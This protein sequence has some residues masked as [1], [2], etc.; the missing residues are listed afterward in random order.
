MRTPPKHEEPDDADLQAPP[1]LVS[2]LKRLPQERLFVPPAVDETVF[3]AA[4]E[5][6]AGDKLGKPHLRRGSFRE[7]LSLSVSWVGTA[8]RAVRGRPV[9]GRA[10]SAPYLARKIW[11]ATS[12]A[13]LVLVLVAY[14]FFS[15]GRGRTFGVRNPFAS[16]PIIETVRT[17]APPNAS[18][19]RRMDILDAFTL[20]RQLKSGPVREPRW[21]INR[22][23]VVDERDVRAIAV[24]VVRLDKGGRS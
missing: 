22:D 2:A 20:A 7:W 18:P 16:R 14:Q 24:E 9:S 11:L 12:A 4:R 3:R 1:E 13:V 23:G 15:P 21:D 6:L 10:A 5:H 8:R 17:P 19:E